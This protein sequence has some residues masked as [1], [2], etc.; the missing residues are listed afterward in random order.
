[1]GGSPAPATGRAE[2]ARG[3]DA[4]AARR[5]ASLGRGLVVGGPDHDQHPAR[6]S[7]DTGSRS[8][9]LGSTASVASVP[10]AVTTMS[11]S[12]A[13]GRC[14]KPSSS[15]CT[16][17]PSVVFGDDARRRSGRAHDHAR[18]PGTARASISGS[19]PAWSTSASTRVPSDTTV[20]SRLRH[21]ARVA[22]GQNRRPL[23]DRDEPRGD[24]RHERRLAG[25]AHAQVADADDGTA[26]PAPGARPLVPARRV[27][28]SRP[29]R[30]CSTRISAAGPAVTARGT[31]ARCSA[32]P[33]AAA[34]AGRAPPASWPWRRGWPRPARGRPRRAARGAPDRP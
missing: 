3:A 30:V 33:R 28:A 27:R 10:A 17:A 4:A 29:Y 14:W 9:P 34:A 13:S 18:A 26:E 19:S 2:P 25:A 8:R 15:T 11:R 32:A 7:A 1:M 6:D 5:G 24:R 23:A 21:R 31:A 16:V 20:G 22:A 12:R